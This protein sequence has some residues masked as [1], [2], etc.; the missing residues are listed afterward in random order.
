MYLRETANRWIALAATLLV[1]VNFCYAYVAMKPLAEAVFWLVLACYLLLLLRLLRGDGGTRKGLSILTGLSCSLVFLSKQIGGLLI[2]H[3]I[4][5]LLFTALTRSGGER[6]ARLKGLM[7]RLAGWCL[8]VL[9]YSAVI[10]HQT[11]HHPLR[12]QFRKGKY[13]IAVADPEVRDEIA[14]IKALPEKDYGMLYAKRRLM[15]RL[16]PN[17][18]DMYSFAETGD[19]KGPGLM[20]DLMKVFEDPKAH[21]E[22]VLSN[23]MSL[24]DPLGSFLLY[25]FLVSCV[26]PFFVKSEARGLAER[27]LLPSLILLYLT[28][29]SDEI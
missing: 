29:Y 19:V 3:M 17:A 5:L 11:D 13:R 21:A 26:S 2:V 10:F 6:T 24:R 18:S 14:R 20:G 7:W 1:Q 9:P 22:R 23:F 8:V 25:L 16:L 4:A 28:G 27:I 15:R 12:Q